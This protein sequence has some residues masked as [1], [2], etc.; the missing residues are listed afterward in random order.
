MIRDRAGNPLYGLAII[1][2]ITDRKRSEEA[3]KQKTREAEEANRMKSQFVS[4]VSHELRTPLNAIIGYNALMRE[5]R[6]WKNAVKRNE[7]LDRISYNSQALL[8]LIN[9]ILDL[10]R[11]EAGKMK[12]HSEE[13]FLSKIVEEAVNHLSIMAG[14]K[15]LRILFVDDRSSLR[16]CRIV[17]SSAKFS[18]I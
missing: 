13:V 8:D 18:S 4:I 12:I 7:M 3:L 17:R 16:F 2:D 11:I 14:D 9:V 1:E 6:F 10:N 15:G 5:S